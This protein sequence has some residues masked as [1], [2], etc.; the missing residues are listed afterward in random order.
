[1][2]HDV[3]RRR[4]MV[5]TMLK[6]ITIPGADL[7]VEDVGQGPVILFVHG[8]PLDHTMWR[9][10]LADL[11]KDFR[12]VAPDLRG[13]GKSSVTEGTVT[14]SQFA[15]DLAALL[16]ALHI[17]EPVAL[18]GLSMGGYINWE[19]ARRHA[20]RLKALIQC[21][22]KAA[23]DTQPVA[24]A[25]LALAR[26]VVLNGPDQLADSMLTRLF[27]AETLSDQPEL[28]EETRKVICATAPTGIAAAARGMACRN[29][30]RLWLSSISQPALLVVGEYDVISPPTEMHELQS[31]LPHSDYLLVDGCGHMAP[32]EKSCKVSPAIR[33]FLS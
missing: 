22:T 18:C 10:Q 31:Q 19:F 7:N 11:S 29:D 30:A 13:F 28:I 8:F 17:N 27:A 24:A 4:P 6:K 21:D 26:D 3:L 33:N 15:D 5:L 23:P 20:H 16:D 9:F 14:M 25:R 32:F 2:R 12:C 1:M